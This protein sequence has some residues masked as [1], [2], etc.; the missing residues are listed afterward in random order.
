M[1]KKMKKDDAGEGGGQIAH[2]MKW[3]LGIA[4]EE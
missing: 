4:N 2:I 1:H 3:K